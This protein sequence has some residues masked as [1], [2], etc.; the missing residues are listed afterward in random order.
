MA[1][2]RCCRSVTTGGRGLG[3]GRRR[4][5]DKRGRGLRDEEREGVPLR[6][7]TLSL[8]IQPVRATLELC[9][10]FVTN[11]RTHGLVISLCMGRVDTYVGNLGVTV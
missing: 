6:D 5:A 3:A 11:L 8:A 1:D 10:R 7:Q 2:V 9:S 4:G